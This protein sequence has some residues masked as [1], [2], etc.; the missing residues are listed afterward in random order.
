[1]NASICLASAIFDHV[2]SALRIAASSAVRVS[3][4]GGGCGAAQAKMTKA[5]LERASTRKEFAFMVF[6]WD[7]AWTKET[8][9]E[10]FDLDDRRAVVV[11]DP[12]RARALRIVD[13]DAADVG[14][15]RQHVFRVLAAIDVEARHA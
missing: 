15:A 13:I 5:R 8:L 2:A 3:A 7:A 4:G 11:A 10:R 6:S 1:M 9:V 12:E 14:R